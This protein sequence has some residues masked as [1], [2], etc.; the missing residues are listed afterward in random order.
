MLAVRIL[1]AYILSCCISLVL[2]LMV[3]TFWDL[4]N[5]SWMIYNYL[6]SHYNIYADVYNY[7]F[8]PVLGDFLISWILLLPIFYDVYASEGK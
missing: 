7:D 6:H 1:I 2:L 5:V 3:G 4:E 8:N